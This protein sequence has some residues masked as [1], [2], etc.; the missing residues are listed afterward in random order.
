MSAT[1][2]GFDA[3]L[4][5]DGYAWWYLDA[6]S[7]DGRFGLCLI[8][9]LGSVFSPYYASARRRGTTAPLNHCAFNIVLRG[10]VKRWCMTERPSSRVRVTPEALRIGPSQLAWDGCEFNFELNERGAPL[11][12]G[13]RGSVRVRP[14]LQPNVICPLD[15]DAHH[16]W[17]PL[18]PC[19]RVDVRLEEPALH[20]QGDGYLDSNRGD[21][22]LEQD[23]QGWQWSRASSSRGTSVFYETQHR[24]EPP[25]PIAL[26]FTANG[27]RVIKTPPRVL[28]PRSGWGISRQ[29]RSEDPSATR[30]VATLV[31]APFYARSLLTT[32]LQG[33]AAVTVHESLNLDRF[34]RPW[35]QWMLPF[36]MPR[37]RGRQR[38]EAL[39]DNI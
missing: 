23:F 19:A 38:A 39:R 35:I 33:E 17:I 15:R 1:G 14:Q 27:A 26:L 31:D 2:P 34:R 29:A 8:A 25:W 24:S 12:L 5:S 13:V 7:D 9:F 22:A 28:L 36:R 30:I 18:A 4:S 32:R 16:A 37:W 6:T 3:E 11:P 21:R 20:W 10:G